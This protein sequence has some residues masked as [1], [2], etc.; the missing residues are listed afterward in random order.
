[1]K[2]CAQQMRHSQCITT[3]LKMKIAWQGKEAS[4][5]LIG[6]SLCR[7]FVWF[8]FFALLFTMQYFI[9]IFFSPLAYGFYLFY[10]RLE[11]DKCETTQ[12][13]MKKTK[14]KCSIVKDIRC[15][16]VTKSATEK[17]TESAWM[18]A[19]NVIAVLFCSATNWTHRKW[20]RVEKR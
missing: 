13:H 1:M 12:W 4:H 5:W 10:R 14:R 9:F 3:N 6:N 2:K 8:V 17:Q 19:E 7:Q 15:M 18:H 16:W 11:Q 20:K